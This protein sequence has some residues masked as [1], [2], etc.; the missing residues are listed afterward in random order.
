MRTRVLVFGSGDC[1]QLGLGEDEVEVA[2]PTPLSF[3]DDKAVCE[4]AA[5][6][7]HNVVRT[8]DGSVWTW[9]CN[10]EQA[11][12]HSASE[13]QIGRVDIPTASVQISAGDSMTAVVTTDGAVWAWGTFRDAEGVLGFSPDSR[14]QALPVCIS[15]ALPGKPHFIKVAAGANH[16]LALTSDHR[17]YAWGCG[18]Q[19]QLGRRILARHKTLAL[20]P[21]NVTPRHMAPITGRS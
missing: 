11:L 15:A 4:V 9:G 5:G 6:G 21:T 19:G 18:A 10:D 3:F 8:T 7:L 13:G 1:G 2:R 17:L 16:V 12:G 14:H 20:R